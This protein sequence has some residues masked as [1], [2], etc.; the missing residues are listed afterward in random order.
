MTMTND[1]EP[2]PPDGSPVGMRSF[3]L[4]S[5]EAHEAMCQPTARPWIPNGALPK[6]PRWPHRPAAVTVWA[7]D[8]DA[9]GDAFR[10]WLW[11]VETGRIGGGQ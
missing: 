11:R 2:G 4:N 7:E 1:R 5:R 10:D 3:S 9:A 8:E 6:E